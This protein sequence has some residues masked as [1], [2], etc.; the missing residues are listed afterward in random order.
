MSYDVN[1]V[2]ISF[3]H[4]RYVYNMFFMDRNFVYGRSSLDT[5]PK[6]PIKIKKTLKQ[7]LKTSTF[8]LNLGVFQLWGLVRHADDDRYGSDWWVCGLA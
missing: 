1:Y 8:F 4:N 5:K 7:N 6:N 2:I 3:T